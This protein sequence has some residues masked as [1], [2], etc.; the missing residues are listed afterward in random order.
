MSRLPKMG[1]EREEKKKKKKREKE[2][3]TFAV[4]HIRHPRAEKRKGKKEG[5]T[6]FKIR[7]QF[8]HS[9]RIFLIYTNE[10]IGFGY[11]DSSF[12]YSTRLIIITEFVRSQVSG[13]FLDTIKIYI[14]IF[15]LVVFEE[16][17]FVGIIT[18][19]FIDSSVSR[20]P[21][22]LRLYLEFLLVKK[23]FISLSRVERCA[24]IYYIFNISIVDLWNRRKRVSRDQRSS[25]ARY[26]SSLHRPSPF[27]LPWH[28]VPACLP[29][30]LRAI[31]LAGRRRGE[32]TLLFRENRDNFVM[33]RTPNA[34]PRL[35]SFL[36]LLSNTTEFDEFLL[37]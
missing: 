29:A 4:V 34:S 33:V 11:I 10:N 35:S 26:W 17:N 6:H 19:N 22:V 3:K 24:C 30:C 25:R 36:S 18:R 32:Q 21:C 12:R 16:N 13:Q 14:Y 8:F 31:P 37:Y 2:R 1:T 15:L 27:A 20:I 7:S 28:L 9:F 23:V 5:G